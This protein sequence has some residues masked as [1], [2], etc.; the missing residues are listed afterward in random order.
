M[1]G[2]VEEAETMTE[3]EDHPRR[4]G[5]KVPHAVVLCDDVG[6]PPQMRGKVYKRIIKEN[7][8]I[9]TPADA[10]KSPEHSGSGIEI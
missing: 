4:C 6:S 8:A 7:G 3:E 2:K 10:G 5:E 1:R 9:I